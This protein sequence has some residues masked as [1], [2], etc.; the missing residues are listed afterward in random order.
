[1]VNEVGQPELLRRA[2]AARVLNIKPQT[3]AAWVSRGQ[4][5]AYVKMG[6]AVRY[7][8]RDLDQYVE[9]ALVTP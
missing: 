6:R 1:M 2:D 4:G 5:P 9:A 7:R 3:L 8:K